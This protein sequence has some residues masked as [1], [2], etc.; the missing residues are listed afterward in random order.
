MYLLAIRVTPCW[1]HWYRRLR[2]SPKWQNGVENTQAITEHWNHLCDNSIVNGF[3]REPQRN[4]RSFS[5]STLPP[6]A[7][8]I[9][10]E[11]TVKANPALFEG[12]GRGW[13]KNWGTFFPANPA[14]FM[15][16]IN[17][18]EWLGVLLTV[19]L[20]YSCLLPRFHCSNQ[21]WIIY[22]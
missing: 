2:L 6:R 19:I 15:C 13:T 22:E 12:E 11:F 8:Y 20:F 14:L 18:D 4:K 21:F 7:H 16:V 1:V 3:S 9:P 17:L 10:E 5:S